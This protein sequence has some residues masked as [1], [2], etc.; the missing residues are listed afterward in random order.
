VL[1]PFREETWAI[2]LRLGDDA[3]RDQVN[4]FLRTFRDQGGFEKLGD[5]FLPQEKAFFKAQGIPFVL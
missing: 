5:E 3:L 4:A 2:G 1:R